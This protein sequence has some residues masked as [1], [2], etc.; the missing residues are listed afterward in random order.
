[1]LWKGDFKYV[2]SPSVHE[3]WSYLLYNVIL[4][5][6]VEGGNLQPIDQ[7]PHKMQH[8]RGD[9]SRGYRIC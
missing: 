8:L 5:Y 2:V 4:L 7:G 1:M 3:S 9:H 6:N